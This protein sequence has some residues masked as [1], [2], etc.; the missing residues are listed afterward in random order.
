MGICSKIICVIY[1][2]FVYY[3]ALMTA[4]PEI[5][6]PTYAYRC[7]GCKH[8]FDAFESIKSEP[9]KNCPQCKKDEL[10]RLIGGGSGV[11]FTGS[12]FYCNDYKGRNASDGASQK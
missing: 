4:S 1:S 8:E 12:G 2:F 7:Q 5:N 11:I 9:Q 3:D 10:C 6:L